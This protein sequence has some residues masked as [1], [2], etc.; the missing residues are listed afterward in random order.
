MADVSVVD[1]LDGVTRTQVEALLRRVEARHDHPALPDAKHAE[2]SGA[3]PPSGF[4]LVARDDASL[5][6]YVHVL[7][8][9]DGTWYVQ[10]VVD[11]D[12]GAPPLAR[13]LTAA[14][15]EEAAARDGGDVRWWAFRA[16]A[17]D[18]ATA[19]SLGL[20]PVREVVQMRRRLPH[21]ADPAL[22]G[23]VR[24]RPFE[25]GR[26][27]DAWL[28]VNRRAFA[29]HPE[30]GSVGPADLAARIA[31][32][33]FDP[34]GFLLVEDD[35]GLCGF[36]WTKVPGGGTG[37]IYAIGTD[38]RRRGEGLGEA[39]VLAGLHWIASTGAETAT[40]Y[41]DGGNEPA[42]ALYRKL[43]FEVDHVDRA[44]GSAA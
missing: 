34:E 26:D 20:E 7:R 37:E 19:A 44:Y 23:D 42:L 43:G 36:C 17:D 3:T 38:P 14:A 31:E 32:P 8:T 2:V 24:L 4:S 25:P 41:V 11:P 15:L 30:Q 40:L 33:W 16:G 28:E 27:D 12:L 1:A 18:D 10:T 29:G 6:G 21:P 13:D 39:L 22:P 35:E 9:G 5:T